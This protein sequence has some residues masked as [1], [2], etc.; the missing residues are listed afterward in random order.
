MDS[1]MTIAVLLGVV[2][3]GLV[4]IVERRRIGRDR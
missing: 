1:L 2:I 3:C 4:L